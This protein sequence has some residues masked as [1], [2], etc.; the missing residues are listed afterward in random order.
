LTLAA[1]GVRYLVGAVDEWPSLLP[2]RPEHLN[3]GPNYL[4]I[5]PQAGCFY[6][7]KT[8]LN[9]MGRLPDNDIVLEGSMVSRRHCVILVHA[10]GGCELHDMASRNGT[11]VNSQPCRRPIRL[12]SGDEIRVCQRLFL[13][14]GENDCQ[15]DVQTDTE[16]GRALLA[17]LR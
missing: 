4:L 11:L 17:V 16:V 9:T 8:G 1:E 2:V 10:W 12:G 7:L 5:D 13:L 15:V 3:P 6:P 14:V